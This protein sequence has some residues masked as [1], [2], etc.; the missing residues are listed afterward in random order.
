MIQTYE[1]IVDEHG[2]IRVLGPVQLPAGN[3]VLVTI[4][5]EPA[6][7]VL[8]TALLSEAALDDWNRPEE[9][10]AWTHL[11]PGL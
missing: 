9:D 5:D 2:N 6:L 11:Q 3:R 8:E 10:E 1:A 7:N 4:L